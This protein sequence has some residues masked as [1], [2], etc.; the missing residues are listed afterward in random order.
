MIDSNA[1][2]RE[3]E[4]ILA[5]KTPKDI[6]SDIFPVE[7]PKRKN[8]QLFQFD[9]VKLG[10]DQ[11]REMRSAVHSKD[12]MQRLLIDALKRAGYEKR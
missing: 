11:V 3:K 8:P 4:Y 10:K 9:K 1:L 2:I 6:R 7:T 12:Y 5:K